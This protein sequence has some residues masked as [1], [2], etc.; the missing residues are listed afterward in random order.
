M[1]VWVEAPKCSRGDI[2]RAGQVLVAGGTSAEL[3]HAFELANAWRASHAFPLNKFQMGLRQRARKLDS[4]AMVAQRLKRMVSIEEKLRREP[5]MKLS[6][7]QDIG[8]CRAVVRSLKVV[9]ALSDLH[10]ADGHRLR[11]D[12]ITEPKDDGYRGVHLVAKYYSASHPQW[13]NQR[14]EIQIRTKLQHAWATAVETVATFS[15]PALKAGGGDSRWRRF[16][17]LMGAAFA[18][19]ESTAPIPNT[20]ASAKDRKDELIALESELRIFTC[21][22]AWRAALRVLPLEKRSRV[23]A[24]VLVLDVAARTIRPLPFGTQRQASAAAAHYEKQA[25]DKGRAWDVVQ[26]SVDSVRSL[27]RLYPNYYS[28][29]RAFLRALKNEISL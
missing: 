14:V 10:V 19:R 4:R 25:K 18:D 23:V 27:K 16:F 5:T 12:Y 28:D 9:R 2:D 17:A 3:E 21:L 24:Y 13:N 20:P 22:E 29:T 11:N 8:G 26:V 7:M 1:T 6:Q 15:A